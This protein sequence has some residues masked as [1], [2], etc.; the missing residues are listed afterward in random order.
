MIPPA[1]LTP[2]MRSR[3]LQAL[4]FIKRY[5]AQ[6]HHSP[7]LGELAS[8]LGVS[9]Q[10]A[11][12]LVERLSDEQQIRRVPGKQRGIVLVDHGQAISEADMLVRLAKL[13]WRFAADSKALSPLTKKGLLD[14]AVLD[15]KPDPD[16]GAGLHCGSDR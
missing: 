3:K 7:S 13:G 4:D 10:R 6:W 5:I 8:H 12:A 11:H 14:L 1:R 15:H 9:R 2:E 16:T